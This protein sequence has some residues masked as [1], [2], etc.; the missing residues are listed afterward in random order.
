MLIR[1]QRC[2]VSNTSS[3]SSNDLC[4]VRLHVHEED[5]PLN[6]PL[7]NNCAETFD[8]TIF[9][10]VSIQ[11]HDTATAEDEAAALEGLASV[12]RV[13]ANRLYDLPKDEVIWTGKNKDAS[14]A[15]AAVKRQTAN[16]TFSPHLMTQVDK[17]RAKGIIGSG[18]KIGVIDTGI[19]YQH[20][21]LGGCFG[22]GCLV[23]YG[24]DIV[25][26]DYTGYNTPAPD[27]E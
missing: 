19:D 18:I 23:S 11:F 22:A 6:M 20:P 8:S 9:K 15:H 13:W 2:S 1:R 21:A 12:K 4:A 17:L 26:D 10:G 14:I 27:N 3:F 25:G 7:A 5:K 24:Y 16:D